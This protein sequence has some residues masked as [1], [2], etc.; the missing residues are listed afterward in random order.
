LA[1]F[2]LFGLVHKNMQF[3]FLYTMPHYYK[4]FIF[5]AFPCRLRSNIF[6]IHIQQF[7]NL[8]FHF[9]KTSL[10]GLHLSQ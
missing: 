7:T 8:Q 1:C 9:L 4:L 10:L 2:T 5:L 3:S 6:W